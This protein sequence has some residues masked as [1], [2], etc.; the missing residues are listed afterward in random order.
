MVLDH[1]ESTLAV[2]ALFYRLL[3]FHDMIFTLKHLLHLIGPQKV[4]DLL[5]LRITISLALY[6]NITPVLVRL[7]I[8]KAI[9]YGLVARPN[10]FLPLKLPDL[11]H[12]VRCI[13]VGYALHCI[14]PLHYL[15][16]DILIKSFNFVCWA[17]TMINRQALLNKVNFAC[18]VANLIV[19]RSIVHV[20]ILIALDL[21]HRMLPSI[22]Q[23][24]LSEMQRRISGFL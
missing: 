9:V 11:E 18:Q 16:V 5:L 3:L 7:R 10:S 6:F 24:V 8:S 22:I 4:L 23:V 15:F 13:I 19:Q 17:I 2:N 14:S 12:V 1:I 21:A 20:R